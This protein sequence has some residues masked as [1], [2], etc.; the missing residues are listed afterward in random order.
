MGRR[1]T[2]A[3]AFVS[4][5]QISI[6]GFKC[7]EFLRR[8]PAAL[9]LRSPSLCFLLT[10]RDI[11]PGLLLRAV[12]ALVSTPPSRPF[13]RVPPGTR[14]L[15]SVPLSG[16]PFLTR[17]KRLSTRIP[18][19]P[20]A[21]RAQSLSFSWRMIS[22]PPTFA[23]VSRMPPPP[24]HF[25]RLFSSRCQGGPFVPFFVF[26]GPETPSTWFTVVVFK[27]IFLPLFF[28]GTDSDRQKKG[29]ALGLR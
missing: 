2:P 20:M 1:L 10:S 24:P 12:Q 3:F 6:R 4:W 28:F 29:R 8:V 16:L 11:N 17:L 21:V 26:L 23:P 13:F 15:P 19:S 14:V 22:R 7:G 18:P 25:A 5:S 9:F 27:S